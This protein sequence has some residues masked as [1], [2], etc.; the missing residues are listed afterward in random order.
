MSELADTALV[1]HAKLL[2]DDPTATARIAE[3]LLPAVV[4]HLRIKYPKQHEHMHVEAASDALLEYLGNPSRFDP[5]KA[6]LDTYIKY[7]ASRD[8]INL[9]NKDNRRAGKFQIVDPVELPE[10]DRNN[11]EHASEDPILRDIIDAADEQDLELLITQT[12]D[13]DIDREVARMVLDG[14]RET[15]E[16]VEVLGISEFDR[17]E[18]AAIVKKHKDR[19]KVRLKRIHSSKE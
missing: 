8:M 1:L 15:S 10:S 14:V 13:S 9:I 7:A 3:L 16:Y 4:S 6:Q 18:Q 12:F 19:V 2:A 5:S 11:I 17:S